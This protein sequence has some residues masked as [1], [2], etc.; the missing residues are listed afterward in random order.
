MAAY[1]DSLDCVGIL[2]RTV[3]DV[4]A[5][6]GAGV[7]R[8]RGQGIGT[9]GS[10]L[11]PC[12]RTDTIAHPCARDSTCVS[13]SIRARASSL[14]A[15]HCPPLPPDSG[16]DTSRPLAG[17]RIGLPIEAALPPTLTPAPL[18]ALLTHLRARGASLVPVRVPAMRLA[19]PAYYVVACAEASSNLARYGGGWFGGAKG[20]AGGEGETRETIRSWGFGEQVRTRILAGTYALTAE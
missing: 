14:L 8:C 11:L 13:A 20:D 5:V 16:S 15:S 9:L 12:P 17:L 7:G 6:F 10:L 2:A 19:L 3:D 1:A 4:E 18:A